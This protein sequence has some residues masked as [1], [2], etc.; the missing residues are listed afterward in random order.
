MKIVSF[1]ALCLL[2]QVHSFAQNGTVLTMD[3]VKLS[4]DGKRSLIYAIVTGKDQAYGNSLVAINPENGQVVKSIFVGSEPKD[5]VLTYD[6]NYMF[7]AFDEVA[8]VKRVDL[9]T[10]A[11]DQQ[12]SLGSSPNYGN[13]FGSS[14][15]TIPNEN[16]IVVVSRIRKNVSPNFAGLAVFKNGVM[17]PRSTPDHTGPEVICSTGKDTIY[18]F[19]S[20][21]NL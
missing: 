14:L 6:T 10:F 5:M 12:F 16:N 15:A 11:V 1:I 13:Y 7:I 3:A 4:Y 20:S 21:S 9:S 18:G 2:T 17:L 8:M 19:G